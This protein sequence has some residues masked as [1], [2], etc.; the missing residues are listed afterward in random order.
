MLL[1]TKILFELPVYRLSENDYYQ[2]F[3]AYKSKKENSCFDDSY[4]INHF[5]GAWEY[6]EIIGFLKFY[7]S[8]N[9]QIRCVYTETNASRKVKTRTKTFVETSHSY[10]TKEIDRKRSNQDII[11]VLDDCISH[12]SDRL[13][14]GR[15]INRSI[16]D[17]TYKHT[18]W[19]TVM[20]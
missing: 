19:Q 13:P 2:K 20:A 14:K 4:L 12:C 18:D 6:N 10:C 3:S 17:S 9:T 1:P 15:F 8:G 16:F 11:K 5:G 7:L